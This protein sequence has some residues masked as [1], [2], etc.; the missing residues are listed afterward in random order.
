MINLRSSQDN[1]TRDVEDP[2]VREKI[3]AIVDKLVSK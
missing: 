3:E 2:G 1:K